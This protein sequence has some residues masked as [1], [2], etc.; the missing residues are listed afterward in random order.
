VRGSTDLLGESSGLALLPL[1]QLLQIRDGVLRRQLLL[2]R[3]IDGPLRQCG[4]GLDSAA[5]SGWFSRLCRGS[6]RYLVRYAALWLDIRHHRLACGFQRLD[7]GGGFFLL[8]LQ[9]SL[10][11]RDGA[12]RRL[13]LLHGVVALLARRYRCIGFPPRPRQLADQR[14]RTFAFPL[15]VRDGCGNR[16]LELHDLVRRLLS[17]RCGRRGDKQYRD[18]CRGCS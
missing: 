12:L 6:R 15:Q 4:P 16:G 8:Q 17:P 1:Q 10:Q 2:H 7:E 13:L 5:R 18:G 3:F 9:Q 11:I 14:C